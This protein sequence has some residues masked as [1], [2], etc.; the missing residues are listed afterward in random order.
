MEQAH[1]CGPSHELKTVLNC[2]GSLYHV[3][4]YKINEV[5]SITLKVKNSLSPFLGCVK[6]NGSN[7]FMYWQYSSGTILKLCYK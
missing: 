4:D 5:L 1:I 3:F 2:D 7:V 6:P